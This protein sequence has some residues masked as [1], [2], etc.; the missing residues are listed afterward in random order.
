ML[1]PCWRRDDFLSVTL[2]H[3]KNANRSD[4]YC[5]VFLVDRGHT[6]DVL[7]V[8]DNF[9]LCKEVR[10]TP[11]H[12]YR[13]NSYNILEGYKFAVDVARDCESS[14]VYL[15]EED[16]WIGKDFFDFHE[17]V[18]GQYDPFCLS[19]VRCQND[20]TQYPQEPESVYYHSTFQSLGIS[21]KLDRLRE[22]VKHA[23]PEYYRSMNSYI[24]S[25]NPTSEYGMMWT[26]QDGL[27]NRL[28]EMS[29][30]KCMYPY[31]GRAYH[32]GFVGYNRPGE[33]LVGSLSERIEKLKSMSKEEMNSHARVYKDIA[34]VDLETDY[35]VSEYKLK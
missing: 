33:A 20:A 3:I 18:Q 22:V 24:R 13:G 34:P 10:K 31:I 28:V 15:I 23:R 35:M 25:L 2:E 16:I 17:T 11:P 5:Y 7:N 14:L 27:I 19:A 26:E 6:Q 30:T 1:I 32:A 4:E 21:W 9:P 29:D 12:R 8:V